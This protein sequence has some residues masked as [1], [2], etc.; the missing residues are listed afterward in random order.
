MNPVLPTAAERARKFASLAMRR[1]AE[2]GQNKIA[3]EIGVSPPTVSRWVS[4][5]LERCCQIL[6]AAGLKLVPIDMQCFPPRKVEILL[7]L[8]RDHLKQ[9][10]SV[11]RLVWEE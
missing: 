4:D 9:L 8:A 6:A 11:D 2:V 10:E 7:E 5:D 1:I 3:S